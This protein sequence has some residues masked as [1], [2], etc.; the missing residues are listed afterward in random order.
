M[1]ISPWLWVLLLVLAPM[2]WQVYQQVAFANG[3]ASMTNRA[4]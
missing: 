4:V 1:L 3:S 2:L